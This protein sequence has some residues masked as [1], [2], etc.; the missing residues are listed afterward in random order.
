MKGE[1]SIGRFPKS[2]ARIKGKNI[3][4]FNHGTI[5]IDGQKALY[6]PRKSGR[7]RING[8]IVHEPRLLGVGSLLSIGDQKLRL[9]VKPSVHT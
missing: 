3:S 4:W 2:G 8:W 5:R 1:T 6:S 7:D 9:E